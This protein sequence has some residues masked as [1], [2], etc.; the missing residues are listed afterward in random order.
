MDYA[1]NLDGS[2]GFFLCSLIDGLSQRCHT[3]CLRVQQAFTIELTRL[4]LVWAICSRRSYRNVVTVWLQL[5]PFQWV[6]PPVKAW[7]TAWHLC[8]L[9][10]T[11]CAM[12]LRLLWWEE[13]NWFIVCVVEN[14]RF[15][16][17]FIRLILHRNRLLVVLPTVWSKGPSL[18]YRHSTDFQSC[19]FS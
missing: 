7:Y 10:V 16:G 8:G 9:F 3:L 2:I 11:Y 14:G 18:S 13:A 5:Y 4:G 15:G 1:G 12:G 17:C 19:I 6:Q